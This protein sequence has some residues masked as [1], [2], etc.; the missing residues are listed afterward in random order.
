[1]AGRSLASISPRGSFSRAVSDF[2]SGVLTGAEMRRRADWWGRCTREG[3][4]PQRSLEAPQG[5]LSMQTG[6]QLEIC[7]GDVRA[8]THRPG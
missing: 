7:E 2:E 4:Y 8:Y 3:S 5:G 6:P 1:M